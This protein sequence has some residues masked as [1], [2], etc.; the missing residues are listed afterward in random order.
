LASQM[1]G[2]YG[3]EGAERQEINGGEEH[4]KAQL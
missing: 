3:K 1:E 4:V 2:G